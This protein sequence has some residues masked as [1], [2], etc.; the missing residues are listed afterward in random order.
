MRAEGQ[1]CMELA[2]SLNLSSSQGQLAFLGF[3]KIVPC[4]A[5]AWCSAVL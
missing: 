4:L 1:L 2:S 5:G 3:H